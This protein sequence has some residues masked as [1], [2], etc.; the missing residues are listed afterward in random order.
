MKFKIVWILAMMLSLHG[1]SRE[2]YGDKIS[3]LRPGTTVAE[4]KKGNLSIGASV[5]AS[6][7]KGSHSSAKAIDSNLA[8]FWQASQS[9][10]WILVDLKASYSLTNICQV[11]QKSSVWKFKVEGSVDKE[12]W[13]LLIDRTKGISGDLFAESVSGVYRYVKLT[14]LGSKDGFFQRVDYKRNEYR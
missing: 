14:V 2:N 5:V 4:V 10:G 7:S 3:P 1:Y 8:S 9:E 12:N 11:F 6:S 13:L